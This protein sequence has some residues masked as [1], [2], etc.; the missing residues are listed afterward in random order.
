MDLLG[1]WSKASD[2]WNPGSAPY[3]LEAD[4]EADADFLKNHAT[5]THHGWDEARQARD[6]D[7]KTDRRFHIG[8]LPVPFMGN[9]S[10]ASI[11]VLMT[12]PGVTRNDYKEYEERAFRSALLANLKQERLDGCL[13]F[14]YLDPQ[15]DWHDGFKYWDGKLGKTIQKLAEARGISEPQ[16]RTEMGDKLAVIQLVPYHSA[17]GPNDSKRL[18]SLPSVHL[19]G[20]FVRDTVVKRVSAKQAIVIAMR[21]V[22]KWDQYLPADLTEEQGVIKSANPGEARAANL[23]PTSRGGCAI[24]RHLGA[25]A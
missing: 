19:A 1:E 11:Y 3:I 4:V 13:P 22:K 10:T 7:C 21:R 16:A 24:L 5:V 8:L 12:N 23:S 25:T 17:N 20:E 6:F 14:P 2:R 9:L 18:N 15:F